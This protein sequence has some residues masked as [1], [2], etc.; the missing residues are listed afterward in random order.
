MPSIMKSQ[1][2]P[3]RP[4]TP[5]RDQ[6]G[7]DRG[8]EGTADHG[9]NGAGNPEDYGS[10]VEFLGDVPGAEEVVDAGVE[11][12]SVN[13]VSAFECVSDSVEGDRFR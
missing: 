5:S 6:V 3:A 4:E 13:L 10:S 2:Q 8:L 9:F 11:S 12:G 7:V 1:H